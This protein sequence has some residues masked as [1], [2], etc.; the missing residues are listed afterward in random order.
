MNAHKLKGLSAAQMAWRAAQ[1]IAEGTYVNLGIGMP[2]LVADH[3]P[4]GREVILHSENG[5]LG[6]GPTAGENAQDEELINAGKKS[7]TLLPG[8]ALFHHADSFAMIRGGHIDLCILGAFQVA[9]NGDLANWSTGAEDAIP[10]I[11]GAMD[12][13]AGV[14]RV[15]VLTKHVAK[16]GSPKL[17]NQCTYP[18]TG[19]G[20]VST[21]YSDLAV[22]KVVDG[23]FIVQ[24]IVDGVSLDDLQAVTGAPLEAAPQV[25]LMAVPDL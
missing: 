22:I 16:D 14:K 17:V 8:A 2:E 24:E 15:V 19:L 20:V 6:V 25:A 12:L 21:V 11:G 4:T 13:V 5:L 23:A 18:L 1:D 7:V 10:A 3:I 9:A